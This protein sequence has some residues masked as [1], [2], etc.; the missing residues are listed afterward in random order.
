MTPTKLF[1]FLGRALMAAVFVNAVQPVL[2]LHESQAYPK[3]S[4]HLSPLLP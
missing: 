3:P 4:R 2:P 1:D